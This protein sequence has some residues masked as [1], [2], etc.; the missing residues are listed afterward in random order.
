MRYKEVGDT[1]LFTH[2]YE[3][4]NNLEPQRVI[5]SGK[6]FIH[7]KQARVGK[8]SPAECDTLFFTS[9]QISHPALQERLQFKQINKCFRSDVFVFRTASVISI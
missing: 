6:R 5:K 8:N 1:E 7:N 2:T 4:G 3:I 9:G